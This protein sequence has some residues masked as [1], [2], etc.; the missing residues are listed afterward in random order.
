MSDLISRQAA[1]DAIDHVVIKFPGLLT[2]R[3]QKTVIDTMKLTKNAI[4]NALI[5][6]P[7]VEPEQK[8]REC[9]SCKHSNNGECAYTEECHECMWVSQYEQQV[10]PE[11]KPGKWIKKQ[12][13]FGQCSI[14]GAV[15]DI[16]NNLAHYCCVCGAKMEVADDI[17]NS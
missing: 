13:P 5:K 16:A 9:V 2:D 17:C 7:S 14:C 4:E 15:F 1:I 12:F 3:Q 8:G 11:K 10:E 6:L